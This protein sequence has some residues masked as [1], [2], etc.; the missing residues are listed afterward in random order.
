MGGLRHEGRAQMRYY[1]DT[2]ILVFLKLNEKD[3]INRDVGSVVFGYENTLLTSSVCVTE[4]LHLI[5]IGKMGKRTDKTDSL[6]DEIMQWLDDMGIKIVP[7]TTAHL[8]R[9]ADLPIIDDHRD[10]NDRLIIAQA[11][12]DRI[13]I[14]SSDRKFE[15]YI[16]QGLQFVFNER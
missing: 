15:K 13:P 8:R 1:L 2:N 9:Y 10:P 7:V 14:I 3:E 4:M 5:Q 12:A 16:K 6:G 11:I